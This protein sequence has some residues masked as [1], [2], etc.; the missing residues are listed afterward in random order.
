[1]ARRYEE[2]GSPVPATEDGDGGFGRIN[3]SGHSLSSPPAPWTNRPRRRGMEWKIELQRQEVGTIPERC[4]S[5]SSSEYSLYNVG[6]RASTC[7]ALI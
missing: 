2:R 3:G 5:G 4:L 7:I 1:M 6:G